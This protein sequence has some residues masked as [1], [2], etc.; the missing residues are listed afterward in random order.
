M[1][2]ANFYDCQNEQIHHHLLS[3]MKIHL[4]FQIQIILFFN[5]PWTNILIN[6]HLLHQRF[7]WIK[8]LIV[9]D[10]LWQI[11][12][13]LFVWRRI[14]DIFGVFGRIFRFKHEIDERIGPL[15]VFR[16]FRDDDVVKPQI[17]SF[18]RQNIV[19]VPVSASISEASPE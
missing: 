2:N 6:F 13:G 9:N 14:A 12:P 4:Q 18:R 11:L 16:S 10:V 5:I 8:L 7:A 1:H 3:L 17:G 15:G 19:Q